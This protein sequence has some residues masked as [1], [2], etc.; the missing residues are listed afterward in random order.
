M[1]NVTM[2]AAA[3]MRIHAKS[4][5]SLP[6]LRTTSAGNHIM[7]LNV[8]DKGLLFLRRLAALY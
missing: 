2:K 4:L 3:K 5:F 6:F 1:L 8:I 7:V